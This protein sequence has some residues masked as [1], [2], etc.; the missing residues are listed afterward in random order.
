MYKDM[1]EKE[2]VE[3]RVNECYASTFSTNDGDMIC[4]YVTTGIGFDETPSKIF[5]EYFIEKYTERAVD[6]KISECI[7]SSQTT[8]ISNKII[9]LIKAISKTD[10]NNICYYVTNGVSFDTYPFNLFYKYLIKKYT[11]EAIDF[12]ISECSVFSSK[13]KKDVS[14]RDSLP[15]YRIQQLLKDRIDHFRGKSN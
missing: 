11:K 15:N 12:K 1:Y 6:A 13:E 14:S 2:V 8:G 7:A 5:Y 10:A 3:A 4:F 9:M